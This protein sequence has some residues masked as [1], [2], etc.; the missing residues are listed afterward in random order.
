MVQEF[1]RKMMLEFEMTD[2]GLMRYFLGI[3]VKQE[4]GQIFLSQ[5]KYTEDLL[6]KFHMNNC[7][8]V[9]TPLGLNEKLQENKEEEKVDEKRYRSLVGSLIYLT[10]TRPD[11][12]HSVSIVSRY[13]SQPTKSHFAAA[14]RILRY[15]QGTKKIGVKYVK[16]EQCKLVGFS[17]SDWASSLDDR[18]STSGYVFS[19]GSNVIS[20]SSRKQKTVALSS[21]EAEYISATDCACEA[22]WLRRILKDLQMEQK[23][24]TKI[25]CDNMSAIAMTKNP[26]FHARSKHI[27]LRHHFVHELVSKR[28]IHLGFINT[29]DQPADILTKAV[30]VEVFQKFKTRFKITN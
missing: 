22:I 5:E 4:K 24:P 20:W 26:F 14:K 23:E 29:S 27:E 2:L 19:L 15:L 6:K 7:K 11:I 21:A 8:P 17:D 16:E 9:S 25:Y 12:M 30:P 28:E 3:Q 10:N 13:M 18:K 1:K